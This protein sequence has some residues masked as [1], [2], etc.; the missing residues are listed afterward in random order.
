MKLTALR[1]TRPIPLVISLVVFGGLVS[2]CI[3][4]RHTKVNGSR[5]ACE[6]WQ[7]VVNDEVAGRLSDV[8][9]THK[10]RQVRDDAV[11]ATPRIHDASA[12]LTADIENANMQTASSDAQDLSAG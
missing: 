6:H 3:A 11:I 5:L 9:F 10:V 4:I 2:V 1:R 8:E 12:R 7:N